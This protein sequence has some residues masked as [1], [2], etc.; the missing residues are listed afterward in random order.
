MGLVTVGHHAVWLEVV[1]G[2]VEK[3]LATLFGLVGVQGP[4]REPLAV[5]V[6]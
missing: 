3:A 4:A 1:R 5:A 2:S 6:R